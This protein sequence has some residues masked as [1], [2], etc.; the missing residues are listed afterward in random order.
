MSPFAMTSEERRERVLVRGGKPSARGVNRVATR[1]R[2]A[3]VVT[4]IMPTSGRPLFALNAVRL[5]TAQDY[6]RRELVVVT[7]HGTDELESSLPAD[8]RIRHLRGR[9][10]ESIGMKRNR[11]CEA[12]RGE[13][14]AQWDDD[15]WYGPTRLSVQV[16]PLLA[17]RADVTG[18]VTPVFFDLCSWRFWGVT[19]TLHRRLFVEN[20][21]GGTLVYR[22]EVWERLARYPDASLAEDAYFLLAAKRRG[23]QLQQIPGAGLFMY[24]RH[25]TN[26]WS[27]TCGEHGASA[28]WFRVAEPPLAQEDR[29]FY[30][31]R[32]AAEGRSGAENRRETRERHADRRPPVEVGRVP[33]RTAS[34]SSAP[35]RG[36]KSEREARGDRPPLVTCIMPTSDRR[37]LVRR[38]I[39][40]FDRQDYPNRE[41]LVVDDGDDPVGDL[42]PVDPRFRYVRLERRVVLGEKRNHACELARGS[43]IVHWDD[44]DWYAANRLSYQV[45][46][47]Q[48]HC[49]DLC[50]PGRLLYLELAPARAWLYA[51]P[52]AA[53]V[54]WIAGN[55]LCY[56]IEAWRERPFVGVD[57]GEDTSFVRNR[58]RGAVIV[59]D[60]H[61]FLV[62]I[63]HG[64]NSNP[65]PTSSLGWRP[66]PVG[67][68]RSLLGSDYRSYEAGTTSGGPAHSHA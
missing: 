24:V 33:R 9:R 18:L 29:E 36:G 32:C 30:L 63:I 53:P 67:E 62:G 26:A 40:Y 19:R 57:V 7:D 13:Y 21:H 43:V 27:F 4:C 31:A 56:R 34:P 2:G 16:E 12:A 48:R 66:R 49:A 45:E 61:R 44:D 64:A 25:G 65:K 17:G 11:A 35:R 39:T 38:S 10:R 15:D 58:G 1:R 14:I 46:Q 37:D 42:V 23:A 51:Y 50:G 20:V 55:G 60:D 68:V 47:L 41:L 52:V 6:P 3:A 28:D 59:H 5:F 54:R 22:R 8:P